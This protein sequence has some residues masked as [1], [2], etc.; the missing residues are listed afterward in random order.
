MAE[1]GAAR[2]QE[3]VARIQARWG[4]QALR[5]LRDLSGI[6]AIPTGFPAL[7]AAL[8]IGGV[9]RGQLT[10]LGGIPTSGATTL[11]YHIIASAQ[12]TRD[13]AIYIDVDGRFDPEYASLC[14]VELKRLLLLHPPDASHGLAAAQDLLLNESLNVLVLDGA[15][16]A[17]GLRPLLAPLHGSRC[18]L[19]CLTTASVSESAALGLQCRRADWI[20][21]ENEIVGYQTAVTIQKNKYAPEGGSA[22][23]DMLLEGT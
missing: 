16:S 13:H 20:T 6:E 11:T 12:G 21:R 18:A 10:V 7:D 8:R 3:S 15:F 14:G 9:P 1:Q 22:L 19:L 17:D 5:P 2:I 23:L 4:E